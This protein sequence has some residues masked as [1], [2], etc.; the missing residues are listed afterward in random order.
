MIGANLT[1]YT[2]E[3]LKVLQTAIIR[4]QVMGK[5]DP[6]SKEYEALKLWE[7]KVLEARVQV[8]LKENILLN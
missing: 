2:S 7:T 3:E 8:K 5:H 6:E 4:E 1:D